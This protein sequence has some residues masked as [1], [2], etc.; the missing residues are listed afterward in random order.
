[1]LKKFLSSIVLVVAM[2]MLSACGKSDENSA[3][4]SGNTN[5]NLPQSSEAAS[6][7]PIE[8]DPN[9]PDIIDTMKEN[10]G[11]MS[12]Q[13]ISAAIKRARDNAE[14]AAQKTGQT[15]EQIKQAG[16]AA[17]AVATRAFTAD[18]SQ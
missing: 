8:R 17:E 2:I 15:A 10:A 16:D 5:T 6:D 1:M 13:E 3:E 4:K 7:K 18:L 12:Q 14:E 9:K 11:V